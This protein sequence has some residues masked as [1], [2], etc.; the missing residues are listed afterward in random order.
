MFSG[1]TF[2]LGNSNLANIKLS[3]KGKEDCWCFHSKKSG[4]TKDTCFKLHGKEKALN[5]LAVPYKIRR[6]SLP[7]SWRSSSS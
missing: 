1:K 3:L 2:K 7:N 4:H 6:S 5:R